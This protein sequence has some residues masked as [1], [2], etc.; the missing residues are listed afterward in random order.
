MVTGASSGIGL[1]IVEELGRRRVPV[2]LVARDVDRLNRIAEPHPVEAEVLPAD[3]SDIDQVRTVEGRIEAG[4]RA[5]KAWI[6]S[7][8]WQI[9]LPG[10]MVDAK[11]QLRPWL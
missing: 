5:D 3:L 11:V 4:E 9:E 6:E 8:N 2:V 1:S 10:R 7:G